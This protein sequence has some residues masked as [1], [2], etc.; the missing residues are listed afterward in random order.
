LEHIGHAFFFLASYLRNKEGVDTGKGFQQVELSLEE[1]DHIVFLR[2]FFQTLGGNPDDL[3]IGPSKGFFGRNYSVTKDGKEE[4][5]LRR[6]IDD[7]EFSA[8]EIRLK[9]L[10]DEPLWRSD[11]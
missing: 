9:R 5:I 6:E 11:T 3:T 1:E 4:I 7:G 8:I 2:A 10:L